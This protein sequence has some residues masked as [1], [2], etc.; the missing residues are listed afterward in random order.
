MTH[1]AII[2]GGPTAIYTLNGLT[3]ARKAVSITLFEREPWGVPG[4]PHRDGTNDPAMLA[5]IA[6]REVP[7]VTRTLAKYLHA[8]DDGFLRRLGLTR[9]AIDED[10]FYPSV[11]LGSFFTAELAEVVARLRGLGHTVTIRTKARVTD[12]VPA[13]DGVRIEWQSTQR[14]EKARF[15]HVVIATGH[16]WADY[17]EEGEDESAL[18]SP[19]PTERLK[20]LSGE[21]GIL[22]SSLTAIDVAVTV[23]SAHGAF[24]GEDGDTTTYAVRGDDDPFRLTMM[25]R[26][27]LLPEAD[28]YYPL[29]LPDLAHFTPA[30]IEDLVATDR[31]GLLDRA[32]ALL[33]E[34]LRD[35]DPDY[36]A[37][38]DLSSPEALSKSHFSPRMSSDLWEYARANLVEAEEGR[39]TRRAVP[40]RVALLTAHEVFEDLIPHFDEADLERFHNSLKP[41]F[42]DGYASVPHRSIRRLLALHDAG[43]LELVRIGSALDVS[44]TGGKTVIGSDGEM[45]SF[46]AVVDAR[47]QRPIRLTDL[48]FRSLSRSVRPGWE[49]GGYSLTI[50]GLEKG[51]VQCL[52]MPVL[53]RRRPF[54]QRLVNAAEM[55]ETAAEAIL[56][57]LPAPPMPRPGLTSMK[58]GLRLAR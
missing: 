35:L 33:V 6:S 14:P 40:W 34:D 56:A 12:I 24:E 22:G 32:F 3:R 13:R 15:H 54:I 52:A 57:E 18:L 8:C 11:V 51:T 21:I 5:N 38:V 23:A 53:L 20:A 27:G 36:A 29:P 55:G 49:K 25:S 44:E 28:W 43:R 10:S 2:G 16:D 4:M 58:P 19:W 45:H 31:S 42:T 26:K 39:R 50:E 47:G 46:E 1:I 48:G 7:R 17:E 9:D 30:A 37:S 41:I